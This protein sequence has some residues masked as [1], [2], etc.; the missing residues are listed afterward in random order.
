MNFKINKL[1]LL[2]ALNI[3][4]KAISNKTSLPILAGLLLEAK[5]SKLIITGNDLNLGIETII[6][7][8][9]IEEGSVIVDAS[10]FIAIINKLPNSIVNITYYDNNVNVYCND[11]EFNLVGKKAEEYIEIPVIE[12]NNILKINSNLIKTMIRQTLFA[13]SNDESRPILTGILFKIKNKELTFVSLDG[14]RLALK[15]I[16]IDSIIEN[17]LIIP[18]KTL[19]ELNKIINTEDNIDLEIS[20]TDKH[21]LFNYNNT[22]IIS[23][24][25]EGNFINYEQIIPNDFKFEMIIKTSEFKDSIER[26]YLLSLKS[27][28]SSIKFEIDNNNILIKSNSQN[29]KM[30]ENIKM[31]YNGNKLDIGFNPSYILDVLKV[32]DS[33]K[34]IMKFNNNMSPSIIK[35][36]E[37][38]SYKYMILPVRL[39]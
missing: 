12:K 15:K 38:N 31:L 22:K 17:E 36:F 18:G 34:L 33:E 9:I 11:I 27:K 32:I 3:S 35:P 16:E 4:S 25:L 20:F 13:V 28:K 23:R 26:G 8:T 2:E 1:S 7:A 29:G 6:D 37:D 39:A 10:F 5:D 24:L 14:Y 19:N 30:E 21:I